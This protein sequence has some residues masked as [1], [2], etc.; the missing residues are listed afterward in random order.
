MD[1][2]EIED[3]VS[4]ISVDTNPVWSYSWISMTSLFLISLFSIY[5]IEEDVEGL[6]SEDDEEY[7]R[8]NKNKN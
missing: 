1:H 2:F 6:E 3:L 7:A 4:K 5:P 8:F